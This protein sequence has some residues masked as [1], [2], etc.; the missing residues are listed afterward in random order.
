MKYKYILKEI[1]LI[2]SGRSEFIS[3][4][5]ID[6]DIVY[7]SLIKAVNNNSINSIRVHKYLTNNK[8]LG[9][10]ETARFLATIDLSESTKILELNSEHI[11]KIAKYCTKK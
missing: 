10:V 5:D 1:L 7:D 4:F 9:K 11:N 8:K 6:Y 2:K 3:K